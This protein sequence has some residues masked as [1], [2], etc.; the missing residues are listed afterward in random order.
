MADLRVVDQK[1]TVTAVDPIGSTFDATLGDGTLVEGIVSNPQN[2]PSVGQQVVVFLVGARVV[3]TNE[4][5]ALASVGDPQIS[6]VGASKLSSDTITANL[7]LAS[8][9]LN[10]TSGRRAGITPIGHQAWDDDENLTVSLDGVNNLITGTTQTAIEGRRIVFGAGGDSSQLVF[11][12]ADGTEG[13]INS[14]ADGGVEAIRIATPVE[15]THEGWNGA[16]FQSSERATLNSGRIDVAFGGDSASLLKRFTVNQADTSGTPGT[17]PTVTERFRLDTARAKMA[18]PDVNTNLELI[19][20]VIRNF[21]GAT[22]NEG[23]IDIIRHGVADSRDRSP[24]IQLRGKSTTRAGNLKFVADSV[25]TGGNPRIEVTDTAD[26][27]GEIRASAFVVASSQALKQDIADLPTGA[28]AK[29][30]QLRPRTYRRVQQPGKIRDDRGRDV[31]VPG[32]VGPTEVGLV[33][34][35]SPAEIVSGDGEAIN[36]YALVALLAGAVKELSGQV[37]QL[38][39]RLP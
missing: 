16:T 21:V 1:V 30:R 18:A 3:Y 33:A 7:T 19:N 13:K 34:E 29:V 31:D 38:R 9:I 39:A 14:F 24:R 5:I 8:Q 17:E 27:Y 15:G 36:V 4:G 10:A 37:D 23:S 2:L 28:L 20:N 32:G 22:T 6:A 12:G 25:T 35:E 11:Y 26:N